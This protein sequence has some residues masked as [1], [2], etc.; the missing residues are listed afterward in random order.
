MTP[1][2]NTNTFSK[3][4]SRDSVNIKSVWK[5]SKKSYS[6]IWAQR[7]SRTAVSSGQGGSEFEFKFTLP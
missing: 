5:Q 6:V 7:G 1:Q 3:R 4:D 2:G